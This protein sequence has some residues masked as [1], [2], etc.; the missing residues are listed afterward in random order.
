MNMRS[1]I[2]PCIMT[3][4]CFGAQADPKTDLKEKD[5]IKIELN[6]ASVEE[7]VLLPG[8]GPKKAGAIIKLR[9][10]RPFRRVTQLL[11]VR[12]IGR[13]TLERLRSHIYIEPIIKPQQHKKKKKKRRVVKAKKSD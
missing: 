5:P 13:K 11:R 4:F 2:L 3:L 10:R 12:G 8:I 6:S 7:L 9:E 1:L